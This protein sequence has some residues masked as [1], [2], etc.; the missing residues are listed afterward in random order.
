MKKIIKTPIVWVYKIGL[1]IFGG[2]GLQ[3]VWPLGLIRDWL[4]DFARTTGK[5]ESVIFRGQKIFL[6]PNDN[7]ELS[8]WGDRHAVSENI[9]ILE[10]ILKAGDTAIDVGAN[11]GLMTL[12]MARAVGPAGRVFAF[13]P[14]PENLKLLQKNIEA[15][16]YKNVIVTSA[17][18][19]DHVGILKLFLSDFNPG[20]HRIYNPEE[21]VK[22]WQKNDAV[23]DKLV[24]GKR[25]AIDVPAVSLDEFLKDYKKPVNFIK[26]DV[27]GAEGGAL[28][29]MMG[30]LE[31]NKN[32]QIMTEFWPAGLK[33]FGI[34]AEEFLT[35]LENLGF[36][37]EKNLLLEKYTIENNRSTDLCL[38]R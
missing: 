34:S 7:L 38:K 16:G 23:Y 30:I 33:M 2:L 10:K 36:K 6:D 21:R 18:V 5:P 29:G 22:D 17:A 27:Q 4:S 28:K 8:V 11:I 26:M 31:K 19:S 24:G 35:T 14:A 12:F 1:N 3:K 37:A 13:E 9:E 25:Q 15:N 20:D 32:I